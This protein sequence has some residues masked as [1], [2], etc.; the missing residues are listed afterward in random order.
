MFVYILQRK[1]IRT[2]FFCIKTDGNPL[3]CTDIIYCTDFIKICQCDMP[4]FFIYL[5]RSNWCW[6]LLDQCK[7]QFFILLIGPVYQIFQCRSSKSSGIP[8]PHYNT[9]L[10]LQI[11]INLSGSSA[12]N[13]LSFKY[14]RLPS[15]DGISRRYACKSCDFRPYSCRY[16][17]LIC[18]SPYL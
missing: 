9:P 10:S 4:M 17:S 14:A 2:T 7:S 3:H 11:L 8:C 5:Y 13:F 16:I 15:D 12:T 1:C 18:L 6:N